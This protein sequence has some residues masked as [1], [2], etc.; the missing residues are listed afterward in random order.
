MERRACSRVAS[1]DRASAWAASKDR[2]LRLER[3]RYAEVPRLG[4]LAR[5]DSKIMTVAEVA[6][7]L[8]V[9]RI[10]IYRLIAKGELHP[11]KIGQ[12]LA[13]QSK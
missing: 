7:L 12:R 3:N 11:F 9:H 5:D 13:L 6:A 2:V 8:Q 10:T 1:G 4:S